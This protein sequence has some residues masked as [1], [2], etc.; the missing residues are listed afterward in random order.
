MKKA[1][2][3]VLL[4]TTPAMAQEPA[5]PTP[6]APATVHGHTR[7]VSTDSPEWSA[8]IQLGTHFSSGIVAQKVGVLDGAL[9]L[10]VGLGKGSLA[11]SAEY[12]WLLTDD[13]DPRSVADHA[14][15]NSFRGQVTPYVGL[16]ATVGPGVTLRAPVGVQY[17]MLRDP[18]NFYGGAAVSV[19]R[20]ADE[21]DD[22][23]IGLGVSLFLGA[24][25]LL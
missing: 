9:N 11:V 21:D 3:M 8:G 5:T 13:F 20:L 24:R 25:L 16:G 17:T 23:D 4:M 19:G 18:F 1:L 7:G 6:T 22:R 14:G 10:G 2:F 12:L 15:Y